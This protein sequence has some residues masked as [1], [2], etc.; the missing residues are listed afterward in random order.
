M[1]PIEVP[2]TQSGSMPAFMQRLIDAGLIGTESA[3]P[4]E[5]QDD[6]PRD[7]PRLGQLAHRYSIRC[8]AIFWVV[9]IVRSILL[10]SAARRR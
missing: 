5:D 9:F 2:M 1:A 3:A 10:R 7:R 6:L 4:L 8:F